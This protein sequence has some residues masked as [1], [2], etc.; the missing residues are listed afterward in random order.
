M[1]VQDVDTILPDSEQIS[2][3]DSENISNHSEP[4][5]SNVISISSDVQADSDP[6]MVIEDSGSSQQNEQVVHPHI[7]KW[8]RNHP[9]HQAIG[10]PQL[11]I[12]TR[13]ATANECNFS[14]FLS[15]T[16]PTRVSEALEIQIGFWLCK[17]S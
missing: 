5:T 9:I 10:D 6:V 11:P 14:I 4:S 12:Q 15:N 3:I 8:T 13:A 2:P 7:T 16:E 17:K 1:N